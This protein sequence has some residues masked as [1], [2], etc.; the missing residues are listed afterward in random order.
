MSHPYHSKTMQDSI[1]ASND[2]DMI[3]DWIYWNDRNFDDENIDFELE[4]Y[5]QIMI[6]MIKE[7]E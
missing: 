6:N 2:K 7:S 3:K 1:I 4:F 5:K